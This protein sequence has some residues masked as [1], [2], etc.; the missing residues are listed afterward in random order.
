MVIN[1]KKN[2]LPVLIIVGLIVVVLGF[3]GISAVIDA[4][5]PSTE[6]ANQ[7][8]YYE[9]TDDS[10][11]AI[12]LDDKILDTYATKINGEVYLDFKF[13]YNNISNRFY[14]DSNE[15]ILLYTTAS[16]VISAE[17]EATEYMVGKSSTAFGKT[18]VK[19]TGDGA[20]VH[21]DFV[22]KFADIQ[23]SVYET[24]SRIVIKK[25]WGNINVATSKNDTQVRLSFDIKSPILTDLPA[26]TTV[27]VL[28]EEAG[29]HTV[30]TADGYI[31][32]VESKHLSAPSTQT[33]TSNKQPEEFHHMKLDKPVNLLWHQTFN[34]SANTKIASI[35][36]DAKGVNVVSPT[37]FKIKDNE[38]NL[39]S[40]ASKDYVDYCHSHGVDVWGLVS[41][42]E[43][44]DVDSIYVLTHTSTRQNLVNQIIAKALQYNLDGINIDFEAMNSDTLSSKEIG[45]A[46]IQFLRELSIKCENNDLVLSTDVLIPGGYNDSLYRYNEQTYFVDYVIVMAYDEHYGQKSGAGSV[47]SL[48]WTE[49]AVKDLL[50][51]GVPADQL[52]L[53]IPFYSKL[54]S[55]T[56]KTEPNS[57][58]VTYVIGFENLGMNS[59]KNWMTTNIPSSKWKWLEDCGQF[60]G[61]TTK[62]G[63]IYKMWLEDTTSLEERLK[64]MKSYNLAGAAFWKSGLEVDEVWDIIIKYIN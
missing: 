28:E 6:R 29:W 58:E 36:S 39:S 25:T 33:L 26:G 52:V 64:M 31:G 20:L 59:A 21:L 30:L 44:D 11:V 63:V 8:E 24:P 41:N 34:T 37:W 5:T 15:N 54:W 2:V 7:T 47:A 40:L 60:Y 61:E 3:I 45:D 4:L 14:W 12:I 22:S 17:A 18:I 43:L 46:Y 50:A 49:T 51:E 53:G 27:T 42:F 16:N 23:V 32:Y 56:P 38:G 55:L 35:L 10:Q 57:A 9:I 62:K 1:M 48:A 13:I 19:A